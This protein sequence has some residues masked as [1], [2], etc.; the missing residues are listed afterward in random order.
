[1]KLKSS[2]LLFCVVFLSVSHTDAQIKTTG[3][4]DAQTDVGNPAR[5]GSTVYDPLMQQYTIEG[6]GTNMWVDHDQFHFVWKKMKGDFI[7]RCNAM[8]IGKGVEDHRKFGWMIRSSL[9]SDAGY[10]DVAVH[11]DGL[12]SLQFR[13]TKA[14]VTEEIKSSVTAPN[15]VQ[16]E[17]RGNTFV[18]SVA[19]NGEIF[20][21]NQLS[22]I[23][24]GDEVYVGLFVCSHNSAVSE[25]AVFNN[26]RI[27]V[28]PKTGYV[29]YHDYIG[30][31]LEILDVANGN[32]KIIYQSPKSIQAPN[33]MKDGKTLLYNS[34]GLLYKFD[35]AAKKPSLLSTGSA[36]D[37]NNDHV[38]SFDGKMLAISNT[39]EGEDASNVYT[40]PITG[41]EPKRITKTGPSYLHGW[42]PDGKWLV[43]VGQRNND[44][45][46]YKISS[47]GGDEMKLT[48][49]KGLDDGCEYSPDGKY[50]YFNSVRSGSMQIWRMQPDGSNPEQLTNDTLNNWFPHI[51][52]D[53]KWMVFIS[54]TKEVKADD[55]PFYQRVYIRKMAVDGGEIKAIAYLFGGQ[56]TI[57]TPSWSPDSKH[58]AFISNTDLLFDVYPKE[59]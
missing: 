55:H 26:V 33:W 54:F 19:Q 6:S 5:K 43:F 31:D 23:N 30:S 47:A 12:T 59:K 18:M 27:A 1:M 44:Y 25:K 51:S 15:V 22:D 57:N 11:G 13:R 41:G 24:L 2:C 52:P 40:V 14:G 48:N 53:G 58:I 3:I 46:I 17:R 36:K 50:I 34:Q 16:L 28:P 45:D 29:P 32:S 38:I 8:F 20:T 56:G 9:D 49:S 21:S 42:S 7:L 39:P 4:F 10:A 35:L 37:N